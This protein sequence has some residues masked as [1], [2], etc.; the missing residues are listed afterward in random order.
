M[1]AYL[2]Q[3][4]TEEVSM[5]VADRLIAAPS[6]TP[7]NDLKA[8]LLKIYTKTDYQKAAGR[9]TG[10]PASASSDGSTQFWYHATYGSSAS[11]CR[12]PCS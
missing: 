11:K 7:Y 6:A 5:R 9:G 8:H 12:S 10:D 4:L 2:V 3:A 1:Y